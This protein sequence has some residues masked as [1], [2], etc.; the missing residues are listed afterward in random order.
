MIQKYRE[1]LLLAGLA[2][3]VAIAASL[4]ADPPSEVQTQFP[5]HS[6]TQEQP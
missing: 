5:S 1:E 6:V 2:V 3:L 4:L